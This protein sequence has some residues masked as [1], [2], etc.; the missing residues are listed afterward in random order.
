MQDRT[1]TRLDGVL[2]AEAIRLL[3][4][5][6]GTP[7]GAAD[8]AT[9]ATAA[10]GDF[11]ARI[12]ARA[13][14]LPAAGPLRAALAH[15]RGAIA[16][17]LTA[18]V[19]LAFAGGGGAAHT[20]LAASPGGPVN[21]FHALATLLG[22]PTLTLLVWLMV[23]TLGRRLGSGRIAAVGML[24]RGIFALARRLARLFDRSPAQL[25]MVR[26]TAQVFGAS[27]A[28]RW[29]ASTVS[30][31]I[32]LAYLLGVLAAL[33]L[34]FSTREYSFNWETT[35]L[36]EQHYLAATQL[37]GT[38]PGWLG[39]PVPDAHTVAASSREFE[40]TIGETAAV[41]ARRA[42]AGM[43]LGCLL[44]YGTLPRIA[45]LLVSV[46]AARRATARISID[47]SHPGF[48]RLRRTLMPMARQA[49]IVDPDRPAI[50]E[51]APVTA[52]PPPLGG[53]GPVAV[54]GLEIDAPTSGWPPPVRAIAWEDLGF[55]NDRTDRHR[56]L[57][58]LIAT[59]L[60]PRA[61][62]IV[63]ALTLTPDRGHRMFI[64]DLQQRTG[65]AVLMLLTNGQ[66]LRDRGH[67]ERIS[68]RIE[69]WR[70][71]AE[72]AGVPADRVLEADL[73]HL[74][75]ASAAR[76]ARWLRPESGPEHGQQHGDVRTAPRPSS[77]S[78]AFD[79]IVEH[80]NG[81]RAVPSE[82]ERMALHHA[83]AALY[84]GGARRWNELLHLPAQHGLPD[85]ASITSAAERMA[86][87]LPARL[88][89]SPRWLAAGAL[90]G[91]LGCVAAAALVAPVAIASLP[92]W[93]G[94][95]AAVSAVLQQAGVRRPA[96]P[97]QTVRPDLS[98]P[99]CAAALY[100]LVLHL[101]GRTEA[102]ITRLLDQALGADEPPPMPDAAAAHDWL[103]DVRRRLDDAMRTAE[104]TP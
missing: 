37:L 79:L 60:R 14:A 58:H 17:A 84:R 102:T 85:A 71:V 25:I 36:A 9:A 40:G 99:V 91:G 48:A 44:V 80:A 61:V 20:L 21:V 82:R 75:D 47:T 62:L 57:D 50:A 29:W 23:I 24:G 92:A 46:L 2:L 59:P 88:R 72:A 28:G 78:P 96:K 63:C 33:L 11:E 83:I 49:G 39:F 8:A 42:W 34:H 95:G 31:L 81:W 51:T 87:L 97:E 66:R 22:L 6:G 12:I 70:H 54:F 94:V 27:P 100:A 10:G 86:G 38:L 7:E 93:A 53:V 67:P 68:E 56:V 26:A 45:A 65:I 18:G 77:I 32:W 101:Q 55:V 103:D 35:I 13:Q 52:E 73:D 5:G 43:L 1:Q 98:E 41:A 89:L 19:V 15:L 3:E 30:H 104:A 64:R 69:D 90:A 74:T 4:E 16:L 76:L